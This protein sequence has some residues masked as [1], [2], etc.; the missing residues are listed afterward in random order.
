[1]QIVTAVWVCIVTF[2]QESWDETAINARWGIKAPSAQLYRWR[3]HALLWLRIA[4]IGGKSHRLASAIYLMPAIWY[5]SI[6]NIGLL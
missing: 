6:Y 2:D 1:M 4:A 5:I 3:G